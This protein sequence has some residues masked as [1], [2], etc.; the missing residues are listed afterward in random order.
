MQTPP[1]KM[2]K[3]FTS[4]EIERAARGMKN[5]KSSGIDNINAEYVKYAANEI[6]QGIADILN[7]TAA[8]G[9]YPAE[10]KIGLLTPLPKPGKKQGPP[11]NLRPIILLSVLRKLLAICLIKR[12]WNRLSTQIPLS[13]AAYQV[14]RSTTEQVF[15]VKLL[16]EKAIT[17]SHYNI[18]ILMLDM[19]KAFDT[20]N[21]KLL[22]ED[23]QDVLNEDE[24]HMM[25]VLINDVKIRVRVG[26]ELG[27]EINTE[28][29]IAQET[30]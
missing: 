22:L 11:A 24:M 9:K 16:A 6:H 15:A 4:Q 5:N 26:Q 30:A 10:M 29:G 8:T 18:Y 17:S 3:P 12:C 27:N 20:V 14:G 25:T 21:R 1:V 28:V 7:E 23:L 19:S 2:D 13:Q